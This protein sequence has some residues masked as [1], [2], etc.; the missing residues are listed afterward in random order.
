MQHTGEEVKRGKIN[1]VYSMVFRV[2][3]M[4]TKIR[5]S[6]SLSTITLCETVVC[7]GVCAWACVCME[8]SLG[9]LSP[10]PTNICHSTPYSTKKGS[11]LYSH[12]LTAKMTWER[13]VFLSQKFPNFSLVS[14]S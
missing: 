2:Y 13:Q 9:L 4:K 3:F 7:G 5:I 12:C 11:C 10:S 8:L 14:N 6:K 1:G